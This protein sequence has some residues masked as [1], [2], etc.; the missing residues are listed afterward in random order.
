MTDT[1]DAG[2]SIVFDADRVV[3]WYAGKARERALEILPRVATSVVAGQWEPRLSRTARAVL[4]RQVTRSGVRQTTDDAGRSVLVRLD[5]LLA[6]GARGREL[7]SA[8]VRGDFLIADTLREIAAEFSGASYDVIT[9]GA[10]RVAIAW[11]EDLA[12]LARAFAALD[13]AR[14]KPS[15]VFREISRTVL[16]NVGRAMGLAF[17]TVRMPNIRWIERSVAGRDGSPVKIWVGEIL[18]PEGT[19]HGQSRFSSGE[20]CQACGHGIRSG[21]WV[22]LVLDG[23]GGPA[24]LWV[25]KDCA[26]HL[27]GCR[28]SGARDALFD[29]V[30][31]LVSDPK[32]PP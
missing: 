2:S 19:R 22:P 23:S 18:W 27:F 14:P 7:H 1:K 10:S 30:P 16:D 31:D 15:Y 8:M 32:D 11:T 4:A 29:R 20:Q 9:R 17:E 25:G 13:A 21:R 28:V 5:G 24:S 12:P 3:S 26:R 6:L